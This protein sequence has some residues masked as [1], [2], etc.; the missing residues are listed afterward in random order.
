MITITHNHAEGTLVDGTARGDGSAPVLK[1]HRFRWSRN[2]GSWYLPNTRDRMAQRHVI[3]NTRVGLEA[4]G[5]EVAVE[6]DDTHRATADV[7]ADRE[8]RMSDRAD[9]LDAKADRYA[10]SSDAA[11]AAA[12]QISSG[13]PM[14]QPILVGHHS[15]RRHRR[16]LDR[17]HR[18]HERSWDDDRTAREAARRAEV[19]RAC[20]DTRNT[21]RAVQGRIERLETERRQLTRAI[22]GSTHTFAGGYKETTPPATGDRLARLTAERAQV[23]DKL[24]HWRGVLAQLEEAGA[25]VYSRENVAKG[26]YVRYIGGWFEVLKANPKSVTVPSLYVPGHTGTIP[27]HKI[28]GHRPAETLV[29]A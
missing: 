25:K 4:A 19:T 20:Q 7:E 14:G 2:L 9:A 6:I 8:Q 12:D 15:E 17:M 27:Y 3:E 28:L 23:D 29:D 21:P 24:T 11:V 1:A 18:L 22:E 5:F 10:A 13:I 16:D 26:D